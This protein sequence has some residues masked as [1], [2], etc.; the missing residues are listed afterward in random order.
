MTFTQIQAPA[1]DDL[2]VRNVKTYTVPPSPEHAS[3]SLVGK[4][5]P[6][7]GQD[8]AMPDINMGTCL[9]FS[10]S[11]SSAPLLMESLDAVMERVEIGLQR[12][13]SHYPAVS[14]HFNKVDGV[15]N[16]Q[17]TDDGIPVTLATSSRVLGS[18]Y[19]GCGGR[20]DSDV[21]PRGFDVSDHTDA[22]FAVKITRFACGSIALGTSV[23]HWVCDYAGYHDI[24]V[25]FAL[26]LSNCT[27]LPP[28]DHSRNLRKLVREV[29]SEDIPIR[30]WF[31]RQS[32]GKVWESGDFALSADSVTN[33]ML[34]FSPEELVKLKFDTIRSSRSE[35]WVSTNDT[36]AALLWSSLTAARGL[37]GSG[38]SKAV[39]TV[40]GRRFVPCSDTYVGNVH[41]M[42]SSKTTLDTL[43]ANTASSVLQVAQTLRADLRRLSQGKMAAIIRLQDADR[44]SSFMPNYKPFFGHDVLIS[45]LTKYDWSSLSFGDLGAPTYVSVITS[46]PVQAGPFKIEGSEGSVFIQN[47]PTGFDPRKQTAR[48]PFPPFDRSDPQPPSNHI[49][50]KSQCSEAGPTSTPKLSSDD[51]GF[52]THI[53]NSLSKPGVI[54]IVGI[55]A[56]DVD[57]FTALP[58]LRR[59]AT[60]L[61]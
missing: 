49:K 60:V 24:M 27:V 23:H 57:A 8:L 59:Y 28:R 18:S 13:A 2:R 55:R 6:L 9:F 43:C 22:V 5:V 29:A 40:D 26:C 25:N 58:H 48:Q 17:Y 35:E 33:V 1:P 50:G 11:H 20:I 10:T 37:K 45:N 54:A 12:L 42:H 36:L 53:S 47:A 16:I 52:R 34:Y 30:D 56:C 15:W 19:I 61:P 44:T 3:H 32:G 41:T 31:V 51:K 14:A 7:S 21:L 4:C 38:P 39:L 46:A